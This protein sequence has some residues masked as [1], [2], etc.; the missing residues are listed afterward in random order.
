M[1][2]AEIGFVVRRVSDQHAV[3]WLCKNENWRSDR[4]AALLYSTRH[5]AHLVARECRVRA[6]YDGVTIRVVRLIVR[7]PE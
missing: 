7:V 4:R 6:T 3:T 2:K 5:Y 1:K